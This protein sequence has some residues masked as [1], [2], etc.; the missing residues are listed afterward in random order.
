[1]RRRSAPRC[2][3]RS[4]CGRTLTAPWS[5]SS[6]AHFARVFALADQSGALADPD[7]ACERMK[8]HLQV[9]CGLHG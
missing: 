4:R 8:A 9:A 3:S 2:P 1:M 7:L 6:A 5:I